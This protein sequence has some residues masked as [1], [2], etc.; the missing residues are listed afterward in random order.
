MSNSNNPE[1]ENLSIIVFSLFVSK[2]N[3]VRL[4]LLINLLK[5]LTSKSNIPEFIK[6]SITVLTLFISKF[7]K[8]EP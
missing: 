6:L 4:I 3:T 7:C 1:S 2:L 5:L 8:S